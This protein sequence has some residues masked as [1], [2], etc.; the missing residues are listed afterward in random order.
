MDKPIKIRYIKHTGANTGYFLQVLGILHQKSEFNVEVTVTDL[1]KYTENINYDILLYQT[2]PDHSNKK[3][4]PSLV[5]K[6]DPLYHEFKGLKILVDAH[7]NGDVDAFS[8]FYETKEQPR[9]KCFP[10]HRFSNEYNIVLNSTISTRTWNTFPDKHRR[11]IIISCKFGHIVEGGFYNHG[12]REDIIKQLKWFFPKE[13][14]FYRVNGRE[15]YIED[16]KRTWISIGAPG[17]GQYSATHQCSLRT[18]ALLFCHESFKDIKYLPHRDLVD[19]AD[20]ISYNLFDFRSKLQRLLDSPGKVDQIRREGRE[21][22]AKGY[23]P[24]RSAQQFYNYLKEE[25]K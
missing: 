22:F 16:L 3:F 5:M 20:Y 2:F 13:T 8:R 10:S 17:W 1:D 12:I 24:Y 9:V 21:S 6:T 14:D 7:D 23:D 15:A 18:G 25:L 19:G 11:K 4:N